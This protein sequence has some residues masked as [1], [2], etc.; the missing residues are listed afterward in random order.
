[1]EKTV[2]DEKIRTMRL[3]MEMIKEAKRASHRRLVVTVDDGSEDVIAFLIQAYFELS[4]RNE[5][6]I[7][8]VTYENGSSNFKSLTEKIEE[9]GLSRK[10]LNL[11]SYVYAESDR[12]LGTTNDLLILD[13][14]RGARPNDIGRLVETVRGGGLIILYN[15][16]SLIHISEPTRPY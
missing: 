15:L 8:Y 14:S 9:L 3:L 13:M 2:Q 6:S 4:G 11:K 7:V 5:M 1:M 10:N 12:L 16:L